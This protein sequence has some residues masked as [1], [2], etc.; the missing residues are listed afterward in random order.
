M[1]DLVQSKV[2]DC[3]CMFRALMRF[4][5]TKALRLTLLTYN[6]YYMYCTYIHVIIF[7]N[8]AI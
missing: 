8:G 5:T 7:L 3:K 2:L 6:K 4:C 1:T